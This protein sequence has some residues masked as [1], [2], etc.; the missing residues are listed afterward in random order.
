M[1][2]SLPPAFCKDCKIL[3]GG[4]WSITAGKTLD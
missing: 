2:N 3:L 4:T 1:S